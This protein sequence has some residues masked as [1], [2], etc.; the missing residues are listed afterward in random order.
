MP[1]TLNNIMGIETLADLKRVS[2][3][4]GGHFFDASAMRYFGS[5][6][7]SRIYPVSQREGYFVTSEQFRPLYGDPDPRL[8][9]VRHYV[10][11]ENEHGHAVVTIDTIEPF[12]GFETSAAAHKVAKSLAGNFRYVS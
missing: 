4:L 8:Y 12:Q 2:S 3:I 6:V 7:S 10:V 1:Y 9:S 11:S 5:R